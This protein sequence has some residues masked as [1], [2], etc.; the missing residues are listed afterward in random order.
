MTISGFVHRMSAFATAA[1]ALGAGPAQAEPAPPASTVATATGDAQAAGPV[2]DRNVFGQFAEMLGTGIYGGVWVGPKS[3]IPN[4]RGIRTDVVEALKALKV[5]NVRWPGGCYADKYHWRNGIG[6]AA[7]RPTTVNVNWGNVLDDNSFGTHEFMDFVDQI[8]SEAYLSVNMAT[9]SVQEAA[10]WL[11]YMTTDQPT[12]L[13]KERQANGRKDP[14]TIAYLGLG[15]EAWG[16][17]GPYSPGDYV[18]QMKL[19]ATHAQNHNPAQRSTM[20]QPNPNGTKY[21]ASAYE[22]GKPEFTEAIMKAWTARLPYFWNIKGV[23]LH[24][25]S[26]IAPLP[27]QDASTDF[28]EDQYAA[29]LADTYTMNDLLAENTAIMDKYDPKKEV[30]LVIDEWGAWL[31][32]LPGTNPMFLRQQNSLRDGLLAAV[33]LNIFARH[34]DRVRMTNIAQMVN[35]IQSMILTDGAKMVL[36]P[37][38]HVYR[39]YVPF[40]DAT[41]IPLQVDGGTYRFDKITLPRVDAIAARAKDGSVWIAAINLDPHAAADF[42]VRLSGLTFARAEG[43]VLTGARVDAINQF[44]VP[45]EVSPAPFAAQASGGALPLRLAPKS[46]TVMRLLP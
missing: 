17:G 29:L 7:K 26:H 24:H 21:I 14:W 25:Y 18:A 33:N 43:E 11:E 16:C 20:M 1:A 38:Y 30:G 9:G 12:T 32:P 27:M 2:I 44:D 35:V 42:S 22:L 8:G 3:A 5:P 10:D 41:L 34:A 36:T 28:G 4:V 40:Q 6:P 37:T 13:G 39:M 45:A 31:K 46:L 23:S 15:N 19:F